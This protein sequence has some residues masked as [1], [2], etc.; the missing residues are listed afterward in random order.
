[1]LWGHKLL[2]SSDT[3][4]IYFR[5][6]GDT[7]NVWFIFDVSNILHKLNTYF[8][9][10]RTRKNSFEVTTEQITAKLRTERTLNPSFS[11]LANEQVSASSQTFMP[12]F[13]T[14]T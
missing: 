6:Q 7:P 2:S 13:K 8:V 14:D 9:L 3:K 10:I 11:F 4:E 1:M 12:K 5:V